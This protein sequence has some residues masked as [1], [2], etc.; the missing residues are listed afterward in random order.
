MST[1]TKEDALNLRLLSDMRCDVV[2]PGRKSIKDKCSALG[3]GYGVTRKIVKVMIACLNDLDR[4]ITNEMTEIAS[5]VGLVDMICKV[6]GCSVMAVVSF[7]AHVPYP[8]GYHSVSALWSYVGVGFVLEDEVMRYNRKAKAAVYR[9]AG[10][11]ISQNTAYKKLYKDTVEKY[12]SRGLQ[13]GHADVAGR[14]A[15]AK[16]WL[17]HL[18]EVSRIMSGLT[19]SLEKSIEKYGDKVHLKED[20]G[21]PSVEKGER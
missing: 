13:K 6:P 18:Y 9:I 8:E 11:L 20:F 1:M 2:V 14:R 5:H 12:L 4:S 3:N 15:V 16:V 7:L 19:T 17:A 21:W 10:G